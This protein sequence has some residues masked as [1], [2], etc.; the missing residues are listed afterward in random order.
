MKFNQL[1]KL[2]LMLVITSVFGL[3]QAFSQVLMS[4]TVTDA[5]TG[6]PLPGVNVV[7]QGTTQGTITDLSGKY[8]MQVPSRNSLLVFSFVGYQ[9]QEILAG[10]NNVIDVRL[11]PG[12]PIDELVVVGY[13]TQRR[14]E[15]TV[16][17]SQIKAEELRDV[18]MSSIDQALAGRATGVSVVQGTGGPGA[19]TSIRIRGSNSIASSSE[20]LYVIDGLPLAASASDNMQNS[21]WQFTGDRIN[22]LASLNPNDIESVEILK[23]ASATSIY[24]ARGANG[25]I[26]ITTKRGRVGR[27]VV[28]F[29][30]YYGVQQISKPMEML[31]STEL[32]HLIYETRT[33]S[34]LPVTNNPDLLSRNMGIPDTHNTDWLSLVSQVAPIQDYNLNMSGG[35]ETGRYSFSVNYFSQD[36]V[37]KATELGR[38][39]ARLNIE[40]TALNDNVKIGGNFSLS[41]TNSQM[42]NTRNIYQYALFSAPNLPP[43]FEDGTYTYNM[44]A[45]Y[46]NDGFNYPNYLRD[47]RGYTMVPLYNT[48]MVKAP[49]LHDRVF[50]NVYADVKLFAG[51]TYRINAGIDV[52]QTKM[53]YFAPEF[54]EMRVNTGASNDAG[55]IVNNTYIVEN[56]L[57]YQNTFGSHSISG[58]LGQSGQQYDYERM[59]F[60]TQ[61]TQNF[62]TFWGNPDANWDVTADAFTGGKT[63]AYNDWKFASYF[64]RLNYSFAGKYL[65]TGSYRIDG[66]SKFGENQ[67]WGKFP[68][69]STA[70]IISNEDFLS[71]LTSLDML[72]LRAG[73]GVVGNSNIANYLSIFVMSNIAAPIGGFYRDA[74][75]PMRLVDKDL[76]W[77]STGQLN[78]GFDLNMMNYRLDATFDFYRKHTWDLI[79][80]QQVSY[81]AG[82]N[83][84]VAT[85]IGEMK[86]TGVEFSLGYDVIRSSDFKWNTRIN[87]SREVSKL[88]KLADDKE[89]IASADGAIRSYVNQPIGQFY[90]YQVEGLWQ[91]GDVITTSAQPNASPGDYRYLD[92]NGY[93]ASGEFTNEPDGNLNDADRVLLGNALPD[94]MWSWNNTMNYKNFDLNFY[95]NGVTGI[96]VYN[97]ARW[98]F[99]S[100]D[101]NINNSKEALNRW[102]PD[103]TNTNVQRAAQVRL[104]GRDGQVNSEFIEDA[105]YARLSNISLGYNISGLSN[106]YFQ[107]IRIY[108]SAQNALLFSKYSGVDPEVT[109]SGLVNRGIDVNSYP[110]TKTFLLGMNI[111]F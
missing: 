30:A 77:E 65:L 22:V 44:P 5:E 71:S 75:T 108:V 37:I 41:R 93:D 11:S 81:A 29:N 101:G 3:S 8:A 34:G 80:A 66:S 36:G 62:Y 19:E 31:N 94:L 84:I 39:S 90:G 89:F 28:N 63:H 2:L 96:S 70:W 92:W 15:V 58:L 51:L 35:S 76:A 106:L 32:S 110:K 57:N 95:F 49:R 111:N 10:A 16:A 1:R 109:G 100:L 104:N 69:I 13:G 73:Y 61:G 107:N 14:G 4:G 68:G 24:G 43:Y 9:Q 17:V 53:K 48:E 87:L 7:V 23:D 42:I 59:A 72:K 64:A 78:I 91:V 50:G 97:Q 47:Y 21:R 105:S 33:N 40:S 79:D 26:L 86:G 18:A 103:N 67:K 102:T 20:P 82:F 6:E 54:G 38:Y 46:F 52:N 12:L 99:L 85:N 74:F 88:T 45:N 60:S 98:S 56:T 27:P 55:H 83:N 25:V